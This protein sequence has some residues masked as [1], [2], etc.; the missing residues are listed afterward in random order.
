MKVW[1][2]AQ[3]W[4]GQEVMDAACADREEMHSQQ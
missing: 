2:S 4:Q 3:R 1:Y